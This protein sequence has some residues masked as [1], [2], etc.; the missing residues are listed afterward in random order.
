MY[1]LSLAQLQVASRSTLAY[2]INIVAFC[3]F[4]L[5][6]LRRSTLETR[7]YTQMTESRLFLGY[8]SSFW[9]WRKAGPIAFSVMTPSRVR[10]LA[11]G[12]PTKTKIE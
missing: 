9:I 11:G 10:S 6:I 4:Q 2:N 7:R 3:H 12:A 8:E 5:T 1:I